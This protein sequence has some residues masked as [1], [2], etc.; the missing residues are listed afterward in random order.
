MLVMSFLIV[1]SKLLQHYQASAWFV[2]YIMICCIGK[3]RQTQANAC[4][5]D[6]TIHEMNFVTMLTRFNRIDGLA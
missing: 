2:K 4:Y 1:I 5:K 3:N 6:K